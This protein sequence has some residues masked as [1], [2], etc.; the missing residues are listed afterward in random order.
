M[1]YESTPRQPFECRICPA[2]GRKTLAVYWDMYR[3]RCEYCSFEGKITKTA[4]GHYPTPPEDVNV[5]PWRKG[6]G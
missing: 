1:E 5:H 6:Y 2:C 3:F 4:E